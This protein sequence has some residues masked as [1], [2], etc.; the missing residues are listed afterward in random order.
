MLAAVALWLAALSAAAMA[1]LYQPGYDPT[2]V[3]EGTGT[4]AFGLLLGAVLAMG[5]PTR[6]AAP[7]R[8][9][10][11]LGRWKLGDWKLGDQAGADSAGGGPADGTGGGPAGRTGGDPACRTGGDPACRTR[12]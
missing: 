10:G 9:S 1:V 11:K 6:R 5:W 3:Y 8:A 7:D 12:R 4:R 2:R